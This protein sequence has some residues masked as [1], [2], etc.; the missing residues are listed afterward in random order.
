MF[1]YQPT[2]S[3]LELKEDKSTDYVIGWKSKEVHS[4]KLTPLCT[5]FLHNIK[6]PGCRIRMQFDSSILVVEQNNYMAKIV[7]AYNVHD[8]DWSKNL[9]RNFKLKNCIVPQI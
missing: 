3:T 9:K 7:N 5:D 1:V 6:P 4:S 8:L 2:F